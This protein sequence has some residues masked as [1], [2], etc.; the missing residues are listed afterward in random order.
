MESARNAIRNG[1]YADA[2]KYLNCVLL[3]GDSQFKEKALGLFKELENAKCQAAK[4][5]LLDALGAVKCG[6][7]AEAERLIQRAAGLSGSPEI[8]KA[9][10]MASGF[11]DRERKIGLL[12]ERAEVLISHKQ[13]SDVEKVIR[14]VMLKGDGQAKGK[15]SELAGRLKE[16]KMLDMME[17]GLLHQ[18]EK[19]SITLSTG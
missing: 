6:Q 11:L 17:Q 9:A 18:A 13:Y 16:A 15:A 14:Y 10:A 7:Y 3:E 4:K 19:E 1:Y 8:G 12:L 2:D 5:S